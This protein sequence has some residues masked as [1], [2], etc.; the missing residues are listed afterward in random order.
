M[1]MFG[2]PLRVDVFPAAVEVMEEEDAAEDHALRVKFGT[3]TVAPVRAE[4]T[5]SSTAHQIIIGTRRN[6]GV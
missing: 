1:A 6:A 5:S 4:L 2:A 3:L